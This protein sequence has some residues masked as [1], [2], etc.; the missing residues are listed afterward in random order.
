ME[1]LYSTQGQNIWLGGHAHPVLLPDMTQ[2]GTADKDAVTKLPQVQGTP[3]FPA[4]TELDKAKA[5]LAEKWDK[6]LS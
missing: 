4:S 6:A 5:V 3:S 1:F 2:A